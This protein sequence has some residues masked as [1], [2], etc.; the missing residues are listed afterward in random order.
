M[1][2]IK[3]MYENRNADFFH[4]NRKIISM[5]KM[6]TNFRS[7]RLKKIVYKHYVTDDI[8]NFIPKIFRLKTT[9]LL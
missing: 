1:P 5:G 8:S 4:N 6:I 3:I 7:K 2:K 9:N